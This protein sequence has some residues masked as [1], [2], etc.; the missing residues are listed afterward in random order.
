MTRTAASAGVLLMLI[1]IATAVAVL[2]IAEGP[3]LSFVYFSF[4]NLRS[5]AKCKF[6]FLVQH[7]ART[8]LL[9][10]QPPAMGA[11]CS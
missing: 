2:R 4:V 11:G 9:V 7:C 5:R 10:L 1:G 3:D 8:S 6:V